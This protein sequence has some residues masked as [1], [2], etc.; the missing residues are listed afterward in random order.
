MIRKTILASVFASFGLQAMACEMPSSAGREDLYGHTSAR[1][2]I[3]GLN[4]GFR[5]SVAAMLDAARAELGGDMQI[6][7]GYRSV[8]HQQRLWDQG[9]A[10]YPDPAER[11]KWIAPPGNSMHNYGLAVDLRWNGS[12]IEYGSPI[13]NWMSENM[14]R[15]GLTRPLSNEGWHVEPIGGRANRDA[16]L[17][18]ASPECIEEFDEGIKE[19]PA[20]VLMPWMGEDKYGPQH[21]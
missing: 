3:D 12:R 7:S 19:V 1:S 5:D 4:A 15:F 16:F 10:K 11:R 21:W 6:Y 20:I 18:G 13:S 9:A 8:E 14:S 17:A 2:G